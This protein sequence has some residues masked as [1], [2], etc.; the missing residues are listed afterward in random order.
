MHLLPN[1][2]KPFLLPKKCF[3]HIQITCFCTEF[4]TSVTSTNWEDFWFCCIS[5]GLTVPVA[6]DGAAGIIGWNV[7]LGL[8]IK[9]EV[10]G[11]SVCGSG[12]IPLLLSFFFNEIGFTG[13]SFYNCWCIKEFRE[14]LD[15]FICM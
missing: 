7:K 4:L 1:V 11:K 2:Q 13:N 3:V 10:H 9:P 14:E 15:V 12:Y 8:G 6:G 5:Y